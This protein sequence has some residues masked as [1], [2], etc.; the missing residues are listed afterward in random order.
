MIVEDNGKLAYSPS[1]PEFEANLPLL[2]KSM[3]EAY[4][5][6]PA[7]EVWQRKQEMLFL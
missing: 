6:L 7:L 2:V 4:Q 1:I 3:A 5:T